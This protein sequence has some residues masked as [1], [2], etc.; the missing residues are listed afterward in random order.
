MSVLTGIPARSDV[1]M[2]GELTLRGM[3]LPIGGL[4]EKLL[5]AH[6][7]GVRTV[8]LPKENARH[9]EELPPEVR[10]QLELHLVSGMDEVLPL[11]LTRMPRPLHAETAAGAVL[12]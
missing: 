1:A 9:L 8:L 11:A 4:K 3:V 2:T 5:A 6:R 10:D 12:G 7:M